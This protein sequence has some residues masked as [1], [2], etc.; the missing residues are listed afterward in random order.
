V[1]SIGW[2]VVFGGTAIWQVL[3][4]FELPIIGAGENVMFDLLGNLPWSPV[5]QGIALIAVIIFFTTAGDSATNV[6]GSMSQNGRPVPA[7]WATITWG[8]ALGLIALA[9]LLAGGQNALSGLQSIMVSMSVPFALIMIGMAVVWGREL[10]MDPLMLRRRY[11]L[12]AIRKGVM[13][14]IDEHG[15]DFVFGASKV[16]AEEGAGA[17]FD[18]TEDESLT[19][20][21]TSQTTGEES[22]PNPDPPPTERS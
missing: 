17:E 10:M 14:G 15:D 3:E 16:S 11:G 13:R 20:W 12:A 21:Y 2:Y 18:Y 8:V 4:G 6:M 7:R 9:L 5:M 1:I 22:D 19:E